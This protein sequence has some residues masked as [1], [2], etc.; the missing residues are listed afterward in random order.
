MLAHTVQQSRW[1]H[2]PS[3][4][5]TYAKKTAAPLELR[6]TFHLSFDKTA[7]GFVSVF[8]EELNR[9]SIPT[10]AQR[11]LVATRG[12]GQRAPYRLAV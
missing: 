9:E 11:R 6:V 5:D 4:F 10:G 12:G 1:Q 2:P 8:V 7:D 3:C